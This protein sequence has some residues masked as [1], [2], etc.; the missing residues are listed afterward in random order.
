MTDRALLRDS[1]EKYIG[2]FSAE[3]ERI[4]LKIR[5]TAF[6]ADNSDRLAETLALSEN[7]RDLAWTIAML[8]DLGRFEQVAANGSFIDSVSSDHA[9]AGVD[10][11]FGKGRIADFID[12]GTLQEE[13][14]RCIKLAISYHNKHLLPE[15]LSERQRLFCNMIRDADKLDIFRV[16][17]ENTFEIAHEYPPETVACSAV[18]EEVV[19]CFESF[20][21]LDYS[22]RKYPAD[23]FLGHIAMCFGLYFPQSRRLAAEQGYIGRMADFTFTDPE[24]QGKYIRMKEQLEIFLSS[25]S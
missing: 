13:D 18:S 6:V 25:I 19:Q 17:V 4:S 22:K 21:T 24:S 3:D 16:C 12:Q 15:G 20:E 14:L 5:H 9:A 11:L 1:F 2:E 7:D 8:H 10:Y 23:I